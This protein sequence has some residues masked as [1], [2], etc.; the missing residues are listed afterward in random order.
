MKF[1]HPEA[2]P[3]LGTPLYNLVSKTVIFQQNYDLLAHDI[4]SYGNQG[5][6]LDV[7]TGPGWLLIKLYEQSPT[8]HVYGIDISASMVMKATAHV[9]KAGLSGVVEVREGEVCTIPYSDAF[10]DIVVSTGSIHHWKEPTRA[11]NEIYRVLKDGGYALLY[12][13]VSDTPRSVLKEAARDFG[14][15]RIVLLW[16]HAF[17]EPF[18]SREALELLP[19]TSLFSKGSTRFAGVLCCLIMRKKPQNG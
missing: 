17:E 14:R 18:Y 10:F 4:L 15:L 9:E 3:K 2:I 11:L 19:E 13:V 8:L 7:G 16:M 1:F 12:D 6:F 5:N